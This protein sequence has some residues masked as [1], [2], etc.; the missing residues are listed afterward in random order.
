MSNNE[1]WIA[2]LNS[3]VVLAL[4]NNVVP[5]LTATGALIVALRLHAINK[6]KEKYDEGAQDGREKRQRATDKTEPPRAP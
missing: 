6:E 1:V 4:I 3:P 2:F 5:T